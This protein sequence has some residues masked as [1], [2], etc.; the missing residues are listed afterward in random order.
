M[1]AGES[2]V[3]GSAGLD[4]LAFDGEDQVPLLHFGSGGL[5]QAVGKELL[6]LESLAGIALVEDDSEMA[7]AY[8][9]TAVAGSGV[10]AVKF[11]QHFGE[12]LA[13]CE[14]VGDIR[15]ELAVVFA[16]LC[17]VD[18]V[19]I[20]HIPLLLD[21]PPAVLEDVFALLVG[22]EFEF[23]AETDGLGGEVLGI[24]LGNAQTGD[25]EEVLAV[26]G[27]G[28]EAAEAL[29]HD[30]DAAVLEIDADEVPALLE[31]DAVVYLLAIGGEIVITQAAGI[32]GKADYAV[33]TSFEFEFHLLGLL[34]LGAV[35]SFLLLFLLLLCSLLVILQQV[36]DLV[37]IVAAGEFVVGLFVEEHN[38]DVAFRA[39]AAVAAVAELVGGEGH[40][41]AAQGPLEIIVGIS[42]QGEVGKLAG[43]HLYEA[44]IIVVHTLVPLIVG[45]YVAAVRAPLEG[46]VAVGVGVVD[47]F[48]E[49]D[50]LLAAVSAADDDGGAVAQVCQP[51]AVGRYLGGEADLA[52]G[53]DALFLELGGEGEELVF[54]VGEFG[55]VD[56]PLA[57][58]FGGIEDAAA[59]LAEADVALSLGSV[60]D[61]AGVPQFER[62]H[63]YVAAAHDRDLLAV[64]RSIETGQAGKRRCDAV[65]MLALELI[66]PDGDLQLLGLGALLLGVEIPVPGIAQGAVVADAEVADGVVLER[67]NAHGGG[68]VDVGLPDIGVGSPAIGLDGSLAALAE[69]VVVH[70]VRSEHGRPVLANEIGQFGIFTILQFPDVMSCGRCV[71]LAVGILGSDI[72]FVENNSGLVDGNA[73]G[74]LG[75]HAF[76]HGQIAVG[77]SEGLCEID[78]VQSRCP[79]GESARCGRHLIESP[80]INLAVGRYGKRSLGSAVVGEALG[81]AALDG[82]GPD[83]LRTLTVRSEYHVLAVR[84]PEWLGVVGGIGRELHG[85]A[86][87][88]RDHPDVAL[89]HE[90]DLAPIGRY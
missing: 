25:D 14:V 70:A 54:L 63:I 58:P 32:A 5:E 19:H 89:V 9:G 87:G 60:G 20:G 53:G 41:L 16:H 57:V 15:E 28:E 67:G 40:S 73:P 8:R 13:E 46:E 6:D 62:S 26:A 77:G 30:L 84:A 21:Q 43:L 27:R 33:E 29:L 49:E 74:A 68:T 34:G 66:L 52:L 79:L 69:V 82:H 44:D 71:V 17:P 11:A 36:L 90:S 78:A 23:P 85:F 24:G 64:G 35:G 42:A 2:P 55:L 50:L 7:G 61:A 45:E 31:L 75:R 86:A 38:E 12:Q 88:G 81:R 76:G 22:E 37:E 47:T 48:G 72:I 83:I 80:E 39:P 56:G 10:R 18:S 65:G 59:V 51:L 1:L 3:P 4:G